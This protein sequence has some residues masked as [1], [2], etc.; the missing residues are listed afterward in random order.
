MYIAFGLMLAY[1]AWTL[2]F[3]MKGVPHFSVAVASCMMAVS[4][5]QVISN[6]HTW[7]TMVPHVDTLHVFSVMRIVYSFLALV[8]WVLA[9]L[10]WTMQYVATKQKRA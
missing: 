2:P 1:V 3:E 5:H 6:T 7:G 8:F 9:V 4:N 10:S